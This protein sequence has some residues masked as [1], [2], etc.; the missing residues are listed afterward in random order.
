MYTISYIENY[1]PSCYNTPMRRTSLYTCESRRIPS[2]GREIRV[3]ICRPVK[4]AKPREQTPGILWLHGGGY[5][6]GNGA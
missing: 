4:N 2:A 6:T 3:L 1:P 5:A